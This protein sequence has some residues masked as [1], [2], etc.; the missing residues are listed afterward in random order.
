MNFIIYDIEATCWRGM[1]PGLIQE[2]IEI[3]AVKCN[4]YGEPLGEFSRFIRP[5]INPELSLFCRQL[6]NIE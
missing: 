4:Y 6:T 5:Q 1:P 3:G 2:T